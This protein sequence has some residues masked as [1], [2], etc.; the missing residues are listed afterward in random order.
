MI[1]FYVAATI[2]V[3]PSLLFAADWPQFHGPT[4]DG[5]SPETG[6]LKS[7]PKEGPK[8]LWERNVGSGWSGAAV[9][10]D[11]LVAFHRVG[12][13][14]VVEC[15][16]AD[17]GKPIWKYAA[18][19][20]Y[21]DEFYFDNGPRATPVISSGRVY[22]LGAA[23][24]LTCLKFAD[25]GKLWE[26][27][28]SADYPTRKGYFGVGTSPL[29]DDGRVFFNA[30]AKG[31]GVVA[32]DA[33]TGKEMWKA[34]D[35][36]AGYSTPT[37]A[38]FG[39]KKRLVFL[40]RD[41]VLVLDPANGAIV[42]DRSFRARIDA[43]VNAATP[44]VNGDQIFVTSSYNTG[45]LMLEF[46]ADLFKDVWKNDSS[47]SCHYNSPVRVLERLFG[48]HGRQEYGADL[49]CIEWSSGKILWQEKGF[50]CS[51]LILVDDKLIAVNESGE[52]VL[53]DATARRFQELARF[54]AVGNKTRAMP[55][56]SN[57][58]LFV[59]DTQKLAAFALK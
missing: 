17:S 35:H 51:S 57:G 21:V 2:A 6:L 46:Q 28:L 4:R 47:L 37:I 29:V 48:I 26:R 19:T 8:K 55:A 3:A 41:G 16:A 49:R 10:D 11:K 42:H 27:D 34:S 12:D 31:A 9:A 52:I 13:E 45:A 36:R 58:R 23:G 53:I 54:A 33:V 20:G 5:V 38:T 56:F 50:G 18:P 7:W 22:T 32:L 24:R 39:G 25:G 40:T 44:L 1:R 59:R 43:S 14:E 15:L 30:G